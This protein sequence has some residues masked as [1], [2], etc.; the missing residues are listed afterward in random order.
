MAVK[1]RSIA[2]AAAVMSG[3]AASQNLVAS[4]SS[5]VIAYQ[6]SG[7]FGSNPISGFDR[8][9]LAGE[10]FSVTINAC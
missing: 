6:A 1:M 2:I 9:E 8:F 10:P 3:V 7:M 5:T 4:C